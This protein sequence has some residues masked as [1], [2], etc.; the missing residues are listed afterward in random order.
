GK[1]GIIGETGIA[2]SDIDKKGGTAFIHGEIWQAM[3]EEKIKK[4][5]EIEVIGIEGLKLKVK[6]FKGG[7]K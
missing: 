7:K 6:K 1:E 4:G 5:E 3:S 2:R